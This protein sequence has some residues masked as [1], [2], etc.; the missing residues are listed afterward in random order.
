MSVIDVSKAL[1]HVH[2][3]LEVEKQ[4][5]RAIR[6]LA[7]MT[8]LQRAQV[9]ADLS[10]HTLSID[11]QRA[12][13]VLS[14]YKALYKAALKA[15]D[16]LRKESEGGYDTS[17]TEVWDLLKEYRRVLEVF[18][19][20]SL[21][22]E[23]VLD[24][25]SVRVARVSP[26]GDVSVDGIKNAV[27]KEMAALTQNLTMTIEKLVERFL[28]G[29]ETLEREVHE[30]LLKTQIQSTGQLEVN[31]STNDALKK[32]H[33]ETIKLQ[34]R[35]E[36]LT[37]TVK[38]MMELQTNQLQGIQNRL[39]LSTTAASKVVELNSGFEGLS[40]KVDALNTEIS[41]FRTLFESTKEAFKS[42]T[43]FDSRLGEMSKDVSG[44]H[45]KL[46]ELSKI[47]SMVDPH[48]ISKTWN[49]RHTKALEEIQ[50]FKNKARED[51][52]KAV[53]DARKAATAAR[54]PP[55]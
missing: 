11:T 37:N 45:T 27:G 24:E 5:L 9:W 10:S 38:T 51:I 7:P 12:P 22:T 36:S 52:D 42:V 30:I 3:Q 1:Q 28:T 32:Y 50:A 18:K 40:A 21:M 54:K 17:G 2:N 15:V 26:G 14:Q 25:G 16:V 33:T 34:E 8:H 53:Q 20:A 47:V 48:A 39:E 43:T 6:G 44:I 49:E 55:P 46:D 13:V 41:D 23:E 4:W 35:M 29:Q 19:A 31:V